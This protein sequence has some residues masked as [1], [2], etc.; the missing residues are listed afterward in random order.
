ALWG[1]LSFVVSY[2][3]LTNQPSRHLLQFLISTGQL[4]G[5]VAY[6][7]TAAFEGFKHSS[8]HPFHFWFY[9]VFLN[10]FW[11]VI[12]LIVMWSSGSEIVRA[13]NVAGAKAAVGK[14]K[15]MK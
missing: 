4:Y 8:P 10:A 15:K 9:F 6:Y 2:Q 5:D 11:I 7:F 13:L 1:P 12:P 3:I 14:G